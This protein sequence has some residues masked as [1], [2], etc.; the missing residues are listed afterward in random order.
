MWWP[1]VGPKTAPSGPT[2]WP[3]LA[4]GG[5]AGPENVFS[6]GPAREGRAWRGLA[7]SMNQ[8]RAGSKRVCPARG[9]RPAQGVAAGGVGDTHGKRSRQDNG[10]P[11]SVCTCVCVVNL[12]VGYAAHV[13]HSAAHHRTKRPGHVRWRRA[14]DGP[15]GRALQRCGSD[16]VVTWCRAI[17]HFPFSTVFSATLAFVVRPLMQ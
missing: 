14:G 7:F 4:G 17:F 9:H 15:G 6:T 16:Y 2:V 1:A 8:A 13:W 3:V 12:G 10:M 5:R 11:A